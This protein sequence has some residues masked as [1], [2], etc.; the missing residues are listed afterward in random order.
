MHA[1]LYDLQALTAV[2]DA[3][4]PRAESA[5]RLDPLQQAALR[6]LL[7]A[8]ARRDPAELHDALLDLA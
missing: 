1:E 6:R 4:A 2:L 7:L 5:F 3:S 8:V